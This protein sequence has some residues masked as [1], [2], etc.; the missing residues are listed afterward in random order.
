MLSQDR[1]GIVT[2]IDILGWK[3]IYHRKKDA[4]QTLK[5]LVEEMENQAEQFRGSETLKLTV[6]SI[7]D[8]LI[9]SS[10]LDYE[11]ARA[12][13]KH[14]E[15]TKGIYDEAVKA[16]ERHGQ[17][18]A[19]LIRRSIEVE[20][21]IRGATS[22]GEFDFQG[23]VFIGKA[24][25]EA[26]SWHEEAEWIGVHLTPSAELIFSQGPGSHWIEYAPAFKAMEWKTHCVNWLRQSGSFQQSIE[27]IKRAF[28]QMGPI[29][30]DIAPKFTNTLV[31]VDKI[32][33]A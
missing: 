26:A 32:K 15:A 20:I 21:P 7:S 16:I 25:D 1:E 23:N 24:V 28:L 31:F 22:F 19:W 3:G 14:E 11:R 29:T 5:R 4:L 2:F 33:K 9:L 18:C 17:L 12:I 27:E 13:K 6:K 10:Y 8:T 30:P